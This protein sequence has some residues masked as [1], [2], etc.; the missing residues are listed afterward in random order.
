MEQLKIHFIYMIMVMIQ[1]K[2]INW[3]IQEEN[4]QFFFIR[5]LV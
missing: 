5:N 3:R 4:M 1:I 2:L